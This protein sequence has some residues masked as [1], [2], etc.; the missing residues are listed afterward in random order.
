MNVFLG[1]LWLGALVI[2]PAIN[3]LM[4]TPHIPKAK[5]HTGWLEGECWACGKPLVTGDECV[6][7]WMDIRD[8]RSE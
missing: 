8:A 7:C 2:A 6:R 5:S 4:T 3:A 1:L